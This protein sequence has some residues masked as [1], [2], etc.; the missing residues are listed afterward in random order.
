MYYVYKNLPAYKNNTLT[1]VKRN[2]YLYDTAMR[3]GDTELAEQHK[4]YILE[5]GGTLWYKKVL[6][7]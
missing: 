1:R 5:K 7:S 2:Y 6:L 3:M 4:Q